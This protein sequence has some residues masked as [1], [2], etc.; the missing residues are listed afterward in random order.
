MAEQ[1]GSRR[2]SPEVH[3]DL[4]HDYDSQV[5][6]HLARIER[7]RS[8]YDMPLDFLEQMY[9]DEVVN[10]SEHA[11][12]SVERWLGFLDL[13]RTTDRKLVAFAEVHK[14]LRIG[15]YGFGAREKY[16]PYGHIIIVTN[17][18]K[19]HIWFESEKR[20]VSAVLEAKGHELY[21]GNSFR[22]ERRHDSLEAPRDIEQ[23]IAAIE[24]NV[25]PYV[26]GLDMVHS[27]VAG[28]TYDE[29]YQAF[30]AD[31]MFG[32]NPDINSRDL[33]R[34]PAFSYLALEAV[35]QDAC[36]STGRDIREERRQRR[37][38]LLEK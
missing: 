30:T 6:Q 18:N 36:D 5:T 3:D 21:D 35:V 19:A 22:S 23:P 11:A 33:M 25:M 28:D 15:C 14:E 27:V 2:V 4:V 17:P 24:R 29:L 12:E 26:N 7:L 1:L 31:Y 9:G 32:V 8:E 13:L 37:K 10:P 38:L 20:G 34:T 16:D